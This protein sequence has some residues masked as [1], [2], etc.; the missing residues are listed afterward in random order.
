MEQNK[1]VFI[2]SAELGVPFGALLTVASLSSVFFD[3]IQPLSLVVLLVVIA[4]PIVLYMMARK[5]FVASNGFATFSELWTLAIFTTIAGSLICGLVTY[6]VITCFRPDFLYEQV[7]FVID[8]LKHEPGNQELVDTLEKMKKG[9][10]MPSAFDYC[11][12]MFWLTTSLGCLGGMVIAL[13]AGKIPLKNN[14]SE[15]IRTL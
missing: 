6:V 11:L 13:I 5:Y 7:Q 12:Q 1:N 14:D 8:T 4:A 9:N 15:T 3:R 2:I 10:F